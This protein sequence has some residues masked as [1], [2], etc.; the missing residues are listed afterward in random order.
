MALTQC[1]DCGLDVSDLARSCPHCG[2]PA[3]G[4]ATDGSSAGSPPA[5]FDAPGSLALAPSPSPTPATSKSLGVKLIP[6]ET[7]MWCWAA[8]E[9]MILTFLGVTSVSQ[10]QEASEY[11]GSTDC[12]TP[13]N[14]SVCVNGGWPTFNLHGFSSQTTPMLSAQSALSFN[15]LKEQ[16]DRNKPVAFAWHQN[17]GGG[18]M[19]V[20][21]GYQ[22]DGDQNFV[23][24][25]DPWPPNVGATYTVPYSTF[26]APDSTFQHWV[27]YFEITKLAPGGFVATSIPTLSAS[28]LEGSTAAALAS[29]PLSIRLAG[30]DAPGAAN[31][32]ALGVPIPSISLGL[33]QLQQ[34]APS[35]TSFALSGAAVSSVLHPVVLDE[36]IVASLTT[37]KQATGSWSA[38]PSNPAWTDILVKIRQEDSIASK[39]PLGEYFLVDV[40]ALGLHFLG[41][42]TG[43]SMTLI[44]CTSES[45]L[46]LVAGTPKPATTILQLVRDA[47]KRH[48]GNPA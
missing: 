38:T 15:A 40:S 47:A 2:R 19:M 41:R 23:V 34:D 18:H 3:S 14:E 28:E 13:G 21:V 25:N 45:D 35:G 31:S 9:Q 7:R 36:K 29:L 1:R 6:Q 8:S 30:K 39:V 5:G 4:S 32:A 37:R 24:V 44:P 27:D 16:I 12:C 33:N 26:V 11:F 10:C 20:A 43:V 22:I 17:T 42:G 48:N 46:G